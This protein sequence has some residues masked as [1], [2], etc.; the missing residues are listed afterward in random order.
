M[1]SYIFLAFISSFFVSIHL[2]PFFTYFFLSLLTPLLTFLF[3][4]FI[5]LHVTTSPHSTFTSSCPLDLTPLYLFSLPSI[6]LPS[7]NKCVFT[8]SMRLHD[9]PLSFTQ[10]HRYTHTRTEPQEEPCVYFACVCC[11][12]WNPSLMCKLQSGQCN[13]AKGR[14]VCDRNQRV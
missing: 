14:N 8:L 4:R 7:L 1:F 2:H 13:E 10:L 3:L 12:I 6:F 9:A 11:L 5:Y